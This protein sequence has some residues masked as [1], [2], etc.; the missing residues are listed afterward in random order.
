MGVPYKAPVLE[1][2]QA[3]L[4]LQIGADQ[5]AHQRRA[6]HLDSIR[7][8]AGSSAGDQACPFLGIGPP[9]VLGV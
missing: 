2:H 9:P 4:L 6:S 5:D 1:A 7:P 8:E 3:E